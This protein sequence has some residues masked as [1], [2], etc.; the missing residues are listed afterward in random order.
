[1]MWT[2]IDDRRGNDMQRW[3]VVTGASGGIGLEMARELARRGY[4]LVLNARSADKLQ[5]LAQELQ[6]R[7]GTPCLVAAADLAQAHG[8]DALASLLAEQGI[9]PKVLVNNAGAGLF[10]EFAQ[11]DVE[12]TQQTLEL[13]VVALTRLT[14]LLLPALLRQAPS[15]IL[16]VAST[17]AFQPG[18]L[19]AVYFASKAYVLS[20]GEALDAELSGQGVRVT[21]LCPGAT[22]SGFQ[23][24]AQGERSALFRARMASAADVARHGIRAMERGRRVVVHGR[25]NQLLALG[26]K[27]APRRLAT[28]IAAWKLRRV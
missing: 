7:H 18:P 13:N 26:V 9:E 21:T 2:S 25:V 23:A 10:G 6:Q 28:A 3:A 22:S 20:F 27:L 15:H 4:A 1:M 16:N 11:A 8:A 12:Q 24:R 17:A 14:R 5:A 19:M